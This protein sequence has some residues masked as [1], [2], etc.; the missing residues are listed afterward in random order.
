MLSTETFLVLY[1]LGYGFVI[2]LGWAC[3]V[4]ASGAPSEPSRRIWLHRLAVGL[5]IVGV[6]HPALALAGR[7]IAVELGRSDG[8]S[9][10]KAPRTLRVT[11]W[12]LAFGVAGAVLIIASQLDPLEDAP[13]FRQIR[14][15]LPFT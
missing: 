8:L 5:A 7:D 11:N 1:Y 3:I 4:D 15:G 12:A 10:P 2:F 14:T 9:D 6:L 13:I